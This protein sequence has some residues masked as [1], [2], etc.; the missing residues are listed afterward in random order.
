MGTVMG[1]APLPAA[2]LLSH[3]PGW[4]AT[5]ASDLVAL[6]VKTTLSHTQNA[7]SNHSTLQVS[8]PE[9]HLCFI[10]CLFLE[11]TVFV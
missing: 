11:V 5:S 6:L 3:S 7:L 2:L 4:W 1:R 9:V 10:F 8:R